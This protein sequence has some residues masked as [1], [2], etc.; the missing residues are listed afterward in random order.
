MSLQIIELT[1]LCVVLI[2]LLI[3]LVESYITYRLV[4]EHDVLLKENVIDK[5]CRCEVKI[6]PTLDNR[7]YNKEYYEQPLIKECPVEVEHE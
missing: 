4:K 3:N 2:F 1:L 5:K 6:E 7:E